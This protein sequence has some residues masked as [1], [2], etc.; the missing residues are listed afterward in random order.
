MSDFD[1]ATNPEHKCTPLCAPYEPLIERDLE[2]LNESAHIDALY[3][4][5]NLVREHA[6]LLMLALS[7]DTGCGVTMG[8]RTAAILLDMSETEAAEALGEK[9]HSSAVLVDHAISVGGEGGYIGQAMTALFTVQLE[10]G[11]TGDNGAAG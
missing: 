6:A 5:L 3:A 2:S 4:E 11:P 7:Q 1:A 8:P 10:D 9:R